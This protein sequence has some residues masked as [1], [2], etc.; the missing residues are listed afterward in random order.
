MGGGRRRRREEREG[1]EGRDGGQAAAAGR[2]GGMGRTRWQVSARRQR[3][4]GKAPPPSRTGQA[5]SPPLPSGKNDRVLAICRC[6]GADIAASTDRWSWYCRREDLSFSSILRSLWQRE[7]TRNRLAWQGRTTNKLAAARRHAE[8]RA[9]PQ[10]RREV[11]AAAWHAAIMLPLRAVD[12]IHPSA[13]NHCGSRPTLCANC[14]RGNPKAAQ[15][16]PEVSRR[17]LRCM[18]AVQE[19]A[20]QFRGAPARPAQAAAAAISTAPAPTTRELGAC[21]PAAGM[22]GPKDSAL[23][24]AAWVGDLSALRAALAEVPE[25]LNA[26]NHR[27]LTPLHCAV[28]RG[29]TNC[30]QAL[31][32]AGA[33]V[34]AVEGDTGGTALHLA[35]QGGHHACVRTLLDV[36]APIDA[37]DGDGW[38]PLAHAAYCG[39]CDS[40]DALLEAGANAALADSCGRTPLYMAASECDHCVAQLLAAGTDAAAADEEG[41]TPLHRAA[42]AQSSGVSVAS[43]RALANEAAPPLRARNAQGLTPVQVAEAAG[44]AEA[45]QVLRELERELFGGTSA[46]DDWQSE[47][48]GAAAGIAPGPGIIAPGIAPPWPK[49]ALPLCPSCPPAC[50]ATCAPACRRPGL[51]AAISRVPCTAVRGGGSSA[52]CVWPR[53]ARRSRSVRALPD[54]LPCAGIPAGA[55][56][57]ANAAATHAHTHACA[58][59][60]LTVPIL[61][62]RVWWHERQEWVPGRVL[63]WLAADRC[64]PAACRPDAP[65]PL[66]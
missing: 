62:C 9:S 54:P 26:R 13:G 64:A 20:T 42:A 15:P 61:L 35:A 65:L 17:P 33:D 41:A 5:P 3:E 10:R 40:V 59:C 39:Y 55:P 66:W 19:S 31:L 23:H 53:A 43:L 57:W 14:A 21:S 50:P 36:G 44:A 11:V 58:C 24:R 18:H 6:Q 25:Q 29:H 51:L 4:G 46:V 48:D 28:D 52:T 12:S 45:V 32:D 27:K 63:E 1:W 22:S 47:S 34:A 38:T 30:V 16:A 56:G 37:T 7:M 2:T 8:T 49:T 60:G